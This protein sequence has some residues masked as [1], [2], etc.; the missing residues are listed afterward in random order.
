MINVNSVSCTQYSS[1]AKRRMGKLGGSAR[2]CTVLFPIH[3]I[4][5]IMGSRMAT[6]GIRRSVGL[7][8]SL[9]AAGIFFG[10]VLVHD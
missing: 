10:K 4:Y 9:F 3:C 7:L 2:L 5:Q 6:S 8:V 1:P